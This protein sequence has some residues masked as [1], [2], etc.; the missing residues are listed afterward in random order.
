MSASAEYM[1]LPFDEAIKFFRQKIDLPTKTWKDLWQGMH[2]RAFVVAGAMKDDLLADLRKAVDKGISQ[3]TTLHEFRKD[4]DKIIERHGWKYKGGKSWRTGVIFNTNL[5]TA[6]A[7]GH[8]EL[9][10][11][12]DVLKARPFWRYVASSSREPRD[13]HRRWY[14]L[15]LPHD[16][17]FWKTH[18][19][20]NGWGC[21][22]GVVNH[23]AR[24]V[25]RLEE[26][27]KSGPHPIKTDAP[28][29]ET[30]EWVD[31][32]TGET[33]QIPKGIDPGWDYSVG[34]AAWGQRLSDKAMSGWK[35]QGGKAW[36]RLTFGGFESIGRP[37]RIPVDVPIAVEGK[38]VR[39]KAELVSKIKDII[40]GEE[41]IFTYSGG[42]FTYSMVVNAE[43]LARH[44]ALNRAPYIPFLPEVIEQPFE[45]WQSFERHKGTGKVELRHRFVKAVRLSKDQHLL[46]SVQAVDGRMEAWTFFNSKDLKYYNRQR[47][48]KLV[49][50]R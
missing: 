17:E 22:C 28:K 39:D 13:E 3:G 11:D 23:S 9:M 37:D 2:A 47:V 50:G 46:V 21:K 49:W 18:T 6:Y 14:N 24:E 15:V 5:R 43:I 38:H 12:E 42:G 19:P 16:H 20:P 30:R 34:A 35:A 31:K 27:E 4:F 40:G 10:T 45:I 32:A 41:K 33:H 29:I 7:A 44:L 1:G 48:G 26:E 25:E 36:E 8:H